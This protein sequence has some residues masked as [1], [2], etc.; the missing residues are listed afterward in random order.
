[1]K[2]KLIVPSMKMKSKERVLPNLPTPFS[3]HANDKAV[4][5]RGG[6]ESTIKILPSLQGMRKSGKG[7]RKLG[8]N[9]CLFLTLICILLPHSIK[10]DVNSR[11]VGRGVTFIQQIDTNP[12][13][14]IINILKIDLTTPGVKIRC[15]QARDM[16]TTF[17]PSNGREAVHSIALRNNAVAAINA[18][19]FPYTG[20]PLGLAIRDGELLSEPTEYRACLGIGPQGVLIDMLLFLGSCELAD[21]FKIDI[22]GINRIP[23][24]NEVTI[25][26]PSFAQIPNV[27]RDCTVITLREVNLPLKISTQHQGVV[28]SISHVH[29]NQPMPLCPSNGVLIAVN[30]TTSNGISA[31]I[32]LNEVIKIR[33]DLSENSS[34]PVRGKYPGRSAFVRNSMPKTVWKDVLQA[35]GGGPWLIKNGDIISDG[36]EED[37]PKME[38][39]EKRHP[40]SAAGVTRDGTLLLVTIDGRREWSA[41]CTLAELSAIMKGLGAVKALNLDGGGS[42]TMFVGNGVVNAPSDGRERPVADTLLVYADRLPNAASEQ[43]SSAASL[44][45]GITVVAGESIP[46]SVIDMDGKTFDPNKLIWGTEDGLGFVTQKGVFRSF[47]S[48]RSFV[49]SSAAGQ[50]FR[51]PVSVTAAAPEIIKASLENVPNNPPDRNMLHVSVQDRYGNIVSGAEVRIH[52][53]GGDSIPPLVTNGNGSVEVEIVWDV[54][55]GKRSLRLELS[56]GHF[57]VLKK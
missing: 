11:V 31:R 40:R 35:V 18:D 52:V 42:T 41:G 51:I 8:K 10:A 19:F 54:E 5:I 15:G 50:P 28:E 33:L 13:P 27:S 1:M 4:C 38:F 37:F 48:G 6:G 45:N 34:V 49:I 26:A 30:G 23:S 25:L 53:I 29:A 44:S 43:I 12:V 9:I 55:P 17:G 20:D 3:A 46:L 24:P 36:A 14:L 16:V 32:K 57:L 2:Q 56:N 21:G 22:D 39:I 47:H 7:V